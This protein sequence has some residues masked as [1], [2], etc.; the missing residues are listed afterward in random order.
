[1][2]LQRKGVIM[3]QNGMA[4]QLYKYLII[5]GQWKI[6]Q[7]KYKIA[8]M[9]MSADRAGKLLWWESRL[10]RLWWNK[11]VIS[12]VGSICFVTTE[13]VTGHGSRYQNTTL[14][15]YTIVW[16]RYKLTY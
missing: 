3:W 13:D 7:F 11:V 1:M 10:E 9:L 14:T 12:F 4:Q 16:L 6:L 8:R 2:D 15:Y 5:T